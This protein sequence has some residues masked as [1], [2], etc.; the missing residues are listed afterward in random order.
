MPEVSVIIPNY[1]HAPY[2]KQR[3]DSIL[4]QTFQDLEIIILDDHSTDRSIE[5]IERY[6]EH[7]KVAHIV[8]NEKNSGS[9]FKQWEKGI[10]LAKGNWIWIAE[11]DDWCEPTFLETVAPAFDNSKS[12]GIGFCQTI[13]V[14]SNGKIVMNTTNKQ[15][16]EVMSG[17]DFVGHRMLYLNSIFNASMSVFRKEYYFRVSD[18]FTRYKF[19]GDW[20]FWIEIAVQGNVY[21]SG[22]IL[23]YFRK[24]DKDVSSKAFKS[25]LFYVEYLQL[26][27]D[28]YDLHFISDTERAKMIKANFKKYFFERPDTSTMERKLSSEYRKRLGVSYYFMLPAL[29]YEKMSIRIFLISLAI[30]RRLKS[31]E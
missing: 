5:I 13:A 23:N 28:L 21:I 9:T 10:K 7:S 18:R 17:K 6:R 26:T 29:L 11:S 19:C 12:C 27:T 8:Q 14:Q 16:E 2:L 4:N 24:H 31:Q 3:I 15:M 22:K 25:G 1:N 20:L 30:K